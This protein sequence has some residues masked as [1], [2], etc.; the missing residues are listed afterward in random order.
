LSEK[1]LKLE[2]GDIQVAFYQQQAVTIQDKLKDYATN[3]YMS[4]FNDYVSSM[5]TGQGSAGGYVSL[6]PKE[7]PSNIFIMDNP[8]LEKARE[9]LRMNKNGI[10]FSKKG[11]RGPFTSA[12]TLDSI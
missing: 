6:W 10:A 2:A 5:I 11:W 8:D 1:T 7:K 9:V 12:W 4:D 3:N